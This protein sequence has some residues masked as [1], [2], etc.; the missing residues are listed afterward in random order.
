MKVLHQ[1][2]AQCIARSTTRRI[3]RRVER[4]PRIRR[5]RLCGAQGARQVGTRARRIGTR[6]WCAFS[7]CERRADVEATQ[8]GICVETKI[9]RF[10][11]PRQNP[12]NR[13]GKNI[14]SQQPRYAS[15]TRRHLI[16]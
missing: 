11:Q 10:L 7:R 3:F 2:L 15:A 4:R 6:G 13:T 9:R 16:T 5:A 12:G 1:L 8:A 14:L